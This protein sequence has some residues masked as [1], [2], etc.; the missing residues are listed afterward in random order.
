VAATNF[1][2]QKAANVKLELWRSGAGQPLVFLHPGDGFDSESRLVGELA[3]KFDF[4]APSHPGF[5]GS[6]LPD[7]VTTVD[8]VSYIYLDFLAHLKLKNVL[9]V[10]VSLGAW[11]AAEMATK[12]THRLGGLV[13]ADSLGAKFGDRCTRE[14]ADLFSVP[15]YRL[16][17]LFYYDRH[18]KEYSKQTDGALER[19]ARNHETFALLGWS[20]TLHNPKLR[21]RLSLIDVPTLVLWGAEDIVVSPDYGRKFAAEIPGSRFELIDEA[22]HYVHEDQTDKFVAKIKEF[23]EQVIGGSAAASASR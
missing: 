22:G 11:I 20:P 14:I 19:L 18:R 2:N 4:I 8:D 1:H 16:G 6:E 12:C 10:G 13:L 21:R 17:E 5:G 9:L 3:Q 15:Q 7:Y 23:A